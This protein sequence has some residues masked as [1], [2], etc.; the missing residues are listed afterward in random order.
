MPSTEDPPRPATDRVPSGRRAG[1]VVLV[2]LAVTLGAFIW[3]PWDGGAPSPSASAP[4]FALLPA[5]T[6]PDPSPTPRSDAG[7][8]TFDA[9]GDI[10]LVSFS[11]N[12]GPAAWCV[13]STRGERPRLQ[14]VVIEPPLVFT[15]PRSDEVGLAAVSWHVELES[16]RQNKLFEA[17]WTPSAAS[18]AQRIPVRNAVVDPFEAISLEAPDADS[19]TIFR[20]ALVV[21]W[22]GND[23]H[24]IATQR[25]LPP[26]YSALGGVTFAAAPGGCPAVF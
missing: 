18:P 25:L 13:Y 14:S 3:K 5:T 15:G 12:R 7:D 11:Y 6:T 17:E 19:I 21:E 16:N 10:G 24:N 4:P 1:S 26:S 2:V 23:A 8:Y 20:T 9:P 22:L